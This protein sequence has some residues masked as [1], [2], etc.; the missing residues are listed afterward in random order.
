MSMLALNSKM[1]WFQQLFTSFFRTIENFRETMESG[2][3]EIQLPPLDP[4]H[5]DLIDFK[6]YNLTMDFMDL[7][8]FGFKGFSLKSSKIDKK[9]RCGIQY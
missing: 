9:K 6:F 7:D 5:L 1:K 2:V 3:P 4:I 8:L